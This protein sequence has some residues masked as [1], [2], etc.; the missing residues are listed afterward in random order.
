M[1]KR[2]YSDAP[3]ASTDSSDAESSRGD[4]FEVLSTNRGDAESSL[5]AEYDVFLNFRGPDTRLN[6]TDYL[7]HAM[8][9]AGIRVFRDDEEI[10]KGEAIK[11][12]LERA[13]KSSAICI[14]IFSRNYASSAWCLRELA[15]MVNCKAKILPIFFDV[16]PK[17]VKLKTELYQEDL[18]KH[19]EQLGSEVVQR[20]KD[21]LMGVARIKGWDLKDT[22]QGKLIKSIVAEVSNKLNKGDK[23]LPDSLVG[24]K[25]PVEDVMHLI[26]VGIRHI[27]KRFC[28]KKVLI[29]LDD[30]DK[31]DQLSKLADKPDWF[32]P[33]SRIIITSRD[34]TFLQKG[35]EN[36][37]NNVETHAKEFIIYEMRKLGNVHALEL[38]CKHAFSMDSPPHDYDDISREIAH[39]ADGLPL[40]LEVIGSSLYR[41]SKRFWKDTLKKLNSVPNQK[42]CDKLKISLEMLEKEQREIFLDIACHFIGEKTIYPYYMWKAL[43]FYPGSNIIALTRKS[44]I[45][46]DDFDRLL[47]HDMLR[48]VGREIVQQEDFRFP[49][50]RSRLWYPK[51]AFDVVQTRKGT[52]FIIALNLTGLSQEHDFT[53]EAFS[54]LPSLR[55]L[56][57]EGGNL[58]NNDLKVI[59]LVRCHLSTTPDLSTCLNLKILVFDEHRPKS[60]QFGDS[61]HKLERLKRLEIIPAQVRL[62]LLP[63]SVPFHLFPVPST[64]CCLKYL[65]SLKLEGQCIQELHPSIG[66]MAGLTHLSLRGCHSLE[67]L[68]DC[69]GSLRSLL[70]LDLIHTGI[71][72]LPDSIGD[73]KKLEKMKLSFTQISELPNSIGGLESLLVLF[74]RDTK[75]SQLPASTEYLKRLEYLNLANTMITELPKAIGKLEN[76][77]RLVYDGCRNIAGTGEALEMEEWNQSEDTRWPPKLRLLSMSCDDP[78]FLTRLPCSLRALN[79]KDVKPQIEQPLHSK[80]RY[81]TDLTLTRCSWRDI[82]FKQLENLQSLRVEHCE[83][84]VSLSRLSSS[85]KLQKLQVWFCSELIV[86]QGLAELESLEE[87]VIVQCNSIEWLPDLSKLR[88]LRIFYLFECESLLDL[89]SVPSTCQPHVHMCPM[90]PESPYD[91]PDCII[92]WKRANGYLL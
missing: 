85:R 6:F 90:L 49:W 81:L 36:R 77:E 46:V 47:M 19:E 2:K 8:D 15:Y 26:D 60:L 86:I 82:D 72:A 53:S 10:R 33:G 17:D 66:E 74:L 40:A 64:I 50:K 43:E 51:I 18:Q 92:C 23:K 67:K 84:L 32:A 65:S 55:L 68:P 29:V 80:L 24:I 39:K 89:P 75:I 11:G 42:V 34:T 22:G 59:Y 16:E 25:D 61:I 83:S 4:K 58:A 7:Y 56:E 13:I 31:M 3:S 71:I 52:D 41:Q 57:L 69:I 70:E 28:C 76:L 37:E 12:E 78:Q 91:S 30:V 63:A 87:L 1:A 38:F 54:S 21:A 20:W 14:A 35:E 45:K 44:L 9:G 27:G 88:E 62:S 48:D 79:L 5:G 73:L